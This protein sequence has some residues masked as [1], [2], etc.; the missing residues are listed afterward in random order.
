MKK[1]DKSDKVETIYLTSVGWMFLMF[2]SLF[3]R[4]FEYKDAE[5]GLSC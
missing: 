2:E 5:T 4:Y 3:E 1:K